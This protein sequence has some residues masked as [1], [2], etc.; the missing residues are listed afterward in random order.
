MERK[1][2]GKTEG[3]KIIIKNLFIINT[4]LGYRGEERSFETEKR[5]GGKK[6]K[7]RRD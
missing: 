3:S 7:K 6:G 5:R 4:F 2:Y 1:E